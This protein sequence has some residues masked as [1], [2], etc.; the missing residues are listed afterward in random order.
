MVTGDRAYK[1]DSQA[2]LIAAILDSQPAPMAT[3]EPMTPPTLD[4][5]VTKCLAKD[6]EDRWHSAHDLTD[7]LKWTVQERAVPA[8]PG[9]VDTGDSPGSRGLSTPKLR[10][11]LAGAAVALVTLLTTVASTGRAHP[12]PNRER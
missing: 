4:R 1:G 8:P 2:S 11:Y 12:S 5:V 6:P 10:V 7:E 9:G 3:S